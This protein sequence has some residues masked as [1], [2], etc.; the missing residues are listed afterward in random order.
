M[1]K[2]ILLLVPHAKDHFIYD[3]DGNQRTEV[4]VFAR[5]APAPVPIE[6]SR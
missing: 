5:S 1:R 6:V 2:A 3:A 4:M